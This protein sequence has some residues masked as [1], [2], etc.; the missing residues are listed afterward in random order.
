[1]ESKDDYLV[2][3]LKEGNVEKKSKT[4]VCEVCGHINDKDALMCK[5]C[6]NYITKEDK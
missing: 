2:V 3:K 6:S 5:M 4:V 1:M